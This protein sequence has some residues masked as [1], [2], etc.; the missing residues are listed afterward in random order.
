MDALTNAEMRDD[1]ALGD[2]PSM[3]RRFRSLALAGAMFACIGGALPVV[4]SPLFNTQFRSE[5]QLTVQ[6]VSQNA[7]HAAIKATQSRQ[8][9]D[10]IIRALDLGQAEGFAVNSPTIIRIA[11]EVWSGRET[12][13]AEAE[14]ALRQ[15][16]LDALSFTYDAPGQRLIISATA[17]DSEEAAS[18]AERT[19]E[20]FRHAL[21]AAAGASVSPQIE[22]LRRT[23]G[24]ADAAL[25]GFTGKFDAET[26]AR[27]QQLHQEGDA[28]DIEIN[29]VSGQLADLQQKEKR[30]QR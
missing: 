9:A 30:R 27:L 1:A 2:E 5:T 28:R 25:S 12:T 26:L 13:V 29:A 14:Q 17:A 11:S 3:L 6:G 24:R 19:T 4:L 18:I 23:A 7:I 10:N 22:A 16:L 8:T 20:E 21:L 15:R